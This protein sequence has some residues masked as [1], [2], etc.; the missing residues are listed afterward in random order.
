MVSTVDVSGGSDQEQ[1]RIGDTSMLG[2]TNSHRG[3]PGVVQ[4]EIGRDSSP[5]IATRTEDQE[6]TVLKDVSIVMPEADELA[7]LNDLPDSVLFAAGAAAAVDDGVVDVTLTEQQTNAITADD[8]ES[9]T[10]ELEEA[11]LS[12]PEAVTP[13]AEAPIAVDDGVV[14]VALTEQ[15]TNTIIVDDAK[16]QTHKLEAADLSATGM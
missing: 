4:P 16:S 1:V 15:R 9:H 5:E 8:P 11:A 7:P 3:S 10:H 2:P 14:D 13:S 6:D 12:V